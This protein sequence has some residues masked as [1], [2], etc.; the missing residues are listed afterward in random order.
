MSHIQPHALTTPVVHAELTWSTGPSGFVARR[1]G[2][3][4]EML[5]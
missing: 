1:H 5:A 2:I 3:V 4:A